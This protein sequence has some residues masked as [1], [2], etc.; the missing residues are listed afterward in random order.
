MKKNV[1]PAIGYL[2]LGAAAAFFAVAL[3]G[4]FWKMAETAPQRSFSAERA[5]F[6]VRLSLSSAT[7]STALAMA[8]ALPA[9]YVLSRRNFA[10]KSVLEA[11][12][13]LPMVISPVALGALLLIFFDTPTGRFI[14]KV[15]G[16][17]VFETR[18]IV[19][20][21][22]V[23]I[24]GLAVTLA[25]TVFDYVG[26]DYE[27]TARALG[28]GET[29]TFFRVTLPIA[30]RG[31]AASAILVWARAL[32]EFG[33]SVTLAGATTYKTETLPVAIYLAL[34]SADVYHTGVLIILSFAMALAVLFILKKAASS[35]GG[36]Y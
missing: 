1:L 18:G 34:A 28:C 17:V 23:V 22:F 25:K 13:L 2:A 31:L 26:R 6:A 10:G 7:I 24:A 32:G 12:L 33:A 4:L 14:E 11:A 15:T 3:A 9:G 8:F 21:Q 27:D 29:E 36:H 19:A 16:P 20:A 35:Q 5:W 30:S